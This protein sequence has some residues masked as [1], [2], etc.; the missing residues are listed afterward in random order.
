MCAFKT[1]ESLKIR[2]SVSVCCVKTVFSKVAIIMTIDA[3]AACLWL[4]EWHT[5]VVHVL[6][7]GDCIRKMGTDG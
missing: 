5:E 4:H 7:M 2:N 6:R 3:D 1:T